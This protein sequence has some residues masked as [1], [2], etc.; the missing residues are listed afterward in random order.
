MRISSSVSG[1]PIFA[2]ALRMFVGHDDECRLLLSSPSLDSDEDRYT[3]PEWSPAMV[4]DNCKATSTE[5]G[6]T[7]NGRSLPAVQC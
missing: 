4:A 7:I 6:K 2:L 3:E 5:C 1:K